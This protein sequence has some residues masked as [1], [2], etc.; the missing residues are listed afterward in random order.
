[1][2][3][4][5]L[6]LREGGNEMTID[7][8]IK[9]LLIDIANF[10]GPGTSRICQAEILAIQSLKR[11]VDMRTSPCTTADEILPGETE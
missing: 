1:M 3:G 7:E 5:S 8:A 9:V 6:A 10:G 11:V 2:L 4:K